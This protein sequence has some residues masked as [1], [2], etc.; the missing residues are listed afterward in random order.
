MLAVNV[1]IDAL[2]NKW[3]INCRINRTIIRDLS[4]LRFSLGML[5]LEVC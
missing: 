5:V 2:L 3:T 4:A 1:P